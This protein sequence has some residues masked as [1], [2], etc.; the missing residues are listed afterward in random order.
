[1]VKISPGDLI[2]AILASEGLFKCEPLEGELII[3]GGDRNWDLRW[4]SGNAWGLMVIGESWVR[5]YVNLWGIYLRARIQTQCCI[6]RT[7]V[8]V[9]IPGLDPLPVHLEPCFA[10]LH[11]GLI[12]KPFCRI[13][14]NE[15]VGK[16]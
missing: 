10:Y 1:M 3:P 6:L 15:A 16:V 12:N 14:R 9:L 7:A 2:Q 5:I 4:V 11:M 13:N 8:S